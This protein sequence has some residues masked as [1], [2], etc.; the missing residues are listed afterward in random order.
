MENL[1]SS[2]DFR[3]KALSESGAQN[4][5]LSNF[6]SVFRR[7]WQKLACLSLSLDCNSESY[8]SYLWGYFHDSILSPNITKVCKHGEPR[9][10]KIDYQPISDFMVKLCCKL[11]FVL[12]VFCFTELKY[13]SH[14]F[15]TLLYRFCGLN[16]CSALS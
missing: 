12:N 9:A 6:S 13:R 15:S 8:S 14:H 5:T 11:N 3:L 1:S 10:M 2:P 7:T 16:W 4:A